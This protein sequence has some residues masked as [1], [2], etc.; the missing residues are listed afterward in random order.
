MPHSSK[1]VLVIVSMLS[2]I[3]CYSQNNTSPYSVLGIGDIEGSYNNKYSGMGNASI[4]MREPG[5]INNSNAASLTAL[6][7]KFFIMELSLRWKGIIYQGAGLKAP[8]NTTADIAVKRT[9]IG[10]RINKKWASSVGLQPFSSANY[11]YKAKK[12]VEGTDEYLS[13]YYEGTGGVNQFY[14]AN[15][16]QVNKH[17]SLGVTTS[18]LFGSLNQSETLVD[19]TDA[20]VLTTKKNVYLRNYYLNFSM[21]DQRQL[22]KKWKM[23]TGATYSPK[24]SLLA[25]TINQLYNS[26]AELLKEDELTNSRFSL[27][28]VFN[29]GL[30]FT[31]NNQYTF[32]V[33]GQ[34]QNWDELKHKGVNYKLVNSNR[35]SIGFQN[36]NKQKN[37]F[38]ETFE[39]HMF[40]LGLYAGKT[41]LQV[42]GQNLF[43][44]GFSA[45][46]GKTLQSGLGIYTSIEAGQRKSNSLNLLNESYLNLNFTFSYRSIWFAKKKYF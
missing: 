35:L 2:C 20:E 41:Y 17:T 27:P 33:N 37:Y 32:T 4:A 43:D 24:T 1:I 45:G 15:G 8:Y 19:N 23:V 29:A 9:N 14:W 10:F 38:G 46:F 31:K 3:T 7:D 6:D 22:N 18:F 40:Q 44:Y 12:N 42:Y 34:F 28:S 5:T 39:H 16:V 30:A 11:S 36:S 21:Q 13:A 25:E 26:S